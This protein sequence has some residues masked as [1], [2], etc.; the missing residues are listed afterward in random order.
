[1]S[2]AVEAL[3]LA[4][5]FSDERR[6][7]LKAAELLRVWFLAPATR[8]NPNAT[9]AQGVPGR[10][11]GRAEGVLDTMR[12]IRVVEGIGLITPSQSLSRAE[13]AGLEQWFADYSQWMMTSPTGK[14]E[15]DAD[16]NHGLW[17]DYQ[18]ALFSLF[19]R[20]EDCCALGHRCRAR[21]AL[22]KADRSRRQIAARVGEDAGVSLHCFRPASR[23]RA[24]RSRPL[25][26]HRSVGGSAIGSWLASRP[27]ISFSHMWGANRTFPIRT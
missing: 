23:D 14:D 10:T 17:Y 7:A 22:R 2:A 27:S 4:Y 25:L 15:R 5:Y 21:A 6:Y 18:L 8:M 11:P 16:N 9:F 12:L 13:Q 20:R 19:A 3:S 26:E 24:G 1:M